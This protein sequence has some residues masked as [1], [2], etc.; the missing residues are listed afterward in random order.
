MDKKE[1][2]QKKWQAQLDELRAKIEGIAARADKAKA[3]AEI[4]YA[5]GIDALK[6]KQE[7]VKKKLKQ[8]KDASGEASK[9]IKNGMESALFDLKKAVESA[10]RKFK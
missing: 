2:Y 1:A 9:D 7:E 8:L 5:E 10:L 6:A 4:E 3:K